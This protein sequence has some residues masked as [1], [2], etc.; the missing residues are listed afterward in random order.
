MARD[1]ERN[2]GFI[3]LPDL[4]EEVY[5]AGA[6][7]VTLD[8]AGTY[9]THFVSEDIDELPP[10]DVQL[11]LGASVSTAWAAAALAPKDQS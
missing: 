2:L 3:S 6:I 9:G 10:V 5:I 1:Y 7:V 8:E 11:D 4:P